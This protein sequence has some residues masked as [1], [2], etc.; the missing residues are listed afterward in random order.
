MTPMSKHRT[1]IHEKSLTAQAFILSCNAHESEARQRATAV[2][3]RYKVRRLCDAV[4]QDWPLEDITKIVESLSDAST[5]NTPD[6]LGETPL[7][8]AATLGKVEIVKRLLRHGA[9]PSVLNGD[10]ETALFC[11]WNAD[12]AASGYAC[13]ALMMDL[14]DPSTFINVRSSKGQTVLM[15]ACFANSE[16]FVGLLLHNGADPHTKNHRGN[17]AMDIA[18][19]TGASISVRNL[20]AQKLK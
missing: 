5:L 18:N 6:T 1:E 4:R 11:C 17:T 13:A 8:I 19:L 16:E 14:C 15:K 20:L 10:G 7:H 12:S 3:Q 9:K 2:C